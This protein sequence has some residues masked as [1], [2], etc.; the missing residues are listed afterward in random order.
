MSSFGARPEA[1]PDFR[2][3]VPRAAGA[4]RAPAEGAAGLRDD[5][6]A[7]DRR[8]AGSSRRAEDLEVVAVFLCAVVLAVPRGE[9]ALSAALDWV[10]FFFVEAFFFDDV[11]EPGSRARGF[12]AGLMGAGR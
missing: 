4:E 7:A 9:V 2:G 12:L 10:L 3:G 11:A 5:F 6:L 1:L 8:V